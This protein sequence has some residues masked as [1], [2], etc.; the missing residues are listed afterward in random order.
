MKAAR[1]HE[2]GKPLV[3]EDIPVPEIQPD[4]ILVN[5]LTSRRRSHWVTRSP[6]SYTR[7]VGSCPKWRDFR[8]ETTWLSRPD[9]AMASAAIAWSAIRTF[10][11]TCVGP[12]SDRWE[13]LQ[14]SSPSRL[15]I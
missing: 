14:S 1:S 4:E 5:M 6:A 10:V 15:A 9:G 11:L 13:V 8:R 12:D 2:Y 7:S 3:L